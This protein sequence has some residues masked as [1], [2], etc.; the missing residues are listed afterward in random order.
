VAVET[1]A[2]S[3]SGGAVGRAVR[4]TWSSLRAVFANPSLRRI[5]LALAGSMVGDWA[6]ATA[7]LVWAYNAGGT[8]LIGVW[9]AVRLLLMAVIAPFGSSLA[10]RFDRKHVLL[11]SDVTRALLVGLATVMLF[12]DSPTIAI[13]VVASLVS[14]IGVVFRPAQMAWLPALTNKPEELTAANG[15]S[16][17]IE[18]LA[19]FVGPAIGAGLVA[20]TSVEVVFILNAATFVW[21]ALM[22]WGIH[23]HADPE[24]STVA[25]GE[26]APAAEDGEA[27]EQEGMLREMS[28]GFVEVAHNATLRM[29]AILTCAQVVVAGASA[30]YGVVFAVEILETGPAGIGIIDSIFGVGAIVGGFFAIAR[31]MKNRLATDMAA[32]T[33]LWSLPLLL[34]VV[35][36]SPVTVVAATVVMGF[37]NPL[38]DVNFV[39]IVQRVTPDAVLGR[40]FGAFEGAQIG[41]MALGSALAP[42]LIDLLGLRWA[43]TVLA[44]LVGVPALLFLPRCLRLDAT[45]RPPEDTELLRR[46]P[47]FAPMPTAALELLARNV[48]RRHAAAGEA[49]LREGEDSDLFFVI[50]SGRVEVTQAGEV[51]REEGPGEFFGEI[52]LLRDVPRTATVTATEDTELVTV[53]REDFLDAVGAA[54]ESLAA[55]NDVVS[56]RLA[57]A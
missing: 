3:A 17:T 24:P 28:Q 36:P 54:E 52:G 16:S 44:L 46:I 43:L 32:G 39:T 30:V 25:D 48:G 41:S 21:S 22:V 34:V 27:A 33:V 8:A 56:R 40:V 47:I 55:A 49:I 53:A 14:F 4:E 50:E 20:T 13:L 57:R 31:A 35:W 2:P 1:E 51:I 42:F 6:Y 23:P 29:V 11:V 9:M 12:L 38:V 18:S 5:Q 10:D 7:V 19:F 45:L 15:A 26:D 37:G